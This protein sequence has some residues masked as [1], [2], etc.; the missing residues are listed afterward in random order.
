MQ[1]FEFD[2]LVERAGAGS[3]KEAMTPLAVKEAG[4]VSYWGAEFEFPGCPAFSE[5]VAE[6][7][8]R[9]LYAFTRQD[10]AYN[11]RIVWW[12]K[13]M[14]DWEIRPEWIVPTHGTIFALATAIRLFVGEGENMIVITPGYNRYKQAADRLG[15]GTVTSRMDYDEK[16]GCYQ[17]DWEYLSQ[18]LSRA[19]NR[20]LVVC[21]PNNP[22]G[23]TLK[24]EEL[25]HIHELSMQHQVPVFCDEIFAE[26]ILEG[27]TITPFG[28]AA[29]PDSLAITCTSLGK[30]MSLTGV[31]HAN[32]IIPNEK[33][34]E[35]YICQKYA[36]HYGSIDPMLYS[37][38]QHAC[39]QAGKEYVLALREVVRENRR[40][41]TEGLGRLLP[42]ANLVPAKATYLCW[43]DY[44]GLGLGDRALAG[45]LERL[46]FAGDAGS[47]YG[48]S[49]QFYR[50]SIAVPTWAVEKSLAYM[51]KML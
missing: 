3:L 51:E 7:A 19:E 24:E 14:R 1:C 5:G 15:R 36:D 29:G 23:Q 43:I 50:Y 31:N 44:S 17:I 32:V 28:K 10:D 18:K 8:R 46:L 45:F 34:R 37:G 38:V 49:D 16:T 30:C 13:A 2:R 26:V 22:T 39:T 6:C 21:N 33:L 47:E 11:E 40:I 20:L 9:G 25:K 12:L 48:A 4:L 41:L 42:E 27:G 35:R